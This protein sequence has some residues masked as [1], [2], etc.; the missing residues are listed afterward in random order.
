MKDN[1]LNSCWGQ[2][3]FST[4]KQFKTLGESFISNLGFVFVIALFFMG[5][6][7]LYAQLSCPHEME[8]VTKTDPSCPNPENYDI[9]KVDRQVVGDEIFY[10]KV[11]GDACCGD[12]LVNPK[13]GNECFYDTNTAG[14]SGPDVVITE[15]GTVPDD[16]N[17]SELTK[18]SEGFND[19]M[20]FTCSDGSTVGHRVIFLGSLDAGE[21]SYWYYKV[22]NGVNSCISDISHIAFGIVDDDVCCVDELV[23]VSDDFCDGNQSNTLLSEY[24]DDIGAIESETVVWYTDVDRTEG[25]V[26]TETGDLSAEG[27]PY[28]YYALATDDITGCE[29][30]AVLEI[31]IYPDPTPELDTDAVCYG[32]EST[33]TA[34]AGFAD[35]LFF[36]DA[37]END[38]Y[39]AGEEN[40]QQG[41]DNT[42]SAVLADGDVISV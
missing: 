4:R 14:P 12:F 26:I 19:V 23:D 11:S 37:N 35:Y 8:Q 16:C 6:N 38:E 41:V 2:N 18:C 27:S 30:F 28:F 40:L 1:T 20:E 25:N 17:L 21:Y 22:E 33:F 24:N 32:V 15:V 34:T 10:V 29:S 13:S 39:D 3:Y 42:Y 7:D 36:V 9:T 31:V 5:S